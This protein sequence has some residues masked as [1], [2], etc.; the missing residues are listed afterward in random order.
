MSNQ[1]CTSCLCDTPDG[2]PPKCANCRKRDEQFGSRN[3]NVAFT[4]GGSGPRGTR[5]V[6]GDHDAYHGSSD[7]LDGA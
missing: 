3:S 6:D 5:G 4:K 1:R 2:S 7:P